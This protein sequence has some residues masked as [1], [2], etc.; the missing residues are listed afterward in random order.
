MKNLFGK[1]GIIK[2]DDYLLY[3]SNIKLGI[4]VPNGHFRGGKRQNSFI[5]FVICLPKG[6]L[7]IIQYHGPNLAIFLQS[8]RARQAYSNFFNK[9]Y[10]LFLLEILILEPVE[11]A[12]I[13]NSSP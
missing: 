1:I 9:P 3:I 7:K 5:N 2:E 11:E 10:F 8:V 13:L 4:S 6:T 12:Y